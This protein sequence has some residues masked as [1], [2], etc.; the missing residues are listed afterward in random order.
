MILDELDHIT[1][2]AQSLTSLFS[3]PNSTPSTLRII[4][5][6]NTH[7]LTSSSSSTSSISAASNVRTLHF[8]PYTPAQLSE[9]LQSRLKSLT[10]VDDDGKASAD[11]KKFLP[12]STLML[13]TKKVAAL[14]GDVRSL[15]EVLRGAIDLA[16]IASASLP[17]P[18]Q[19]SD[20]NPL[21]TAAPIVTPTH[22]LAALKAYTPSSTSTSTTKSVSP[23]VA[24]VSVAT[25]SEIVAKVGNLGLHARLVILS[26]LLASKRLEA[27]LAISSTTT[28]ASP[29]KK[30]PVSPMKR[31]SSV[32][33]PTANVNGVGIDANQLHTY[34]S[35]ILNRSDG[36]VLEPV[37]RGEYG[38]LVGVL[39]GVG[40]I[41]MGGTADATTSTGAKRA[42]GR[43]ASFGGA[44]GFGGTG[45]GKGKGDVRLAKGVRADEVLRGLG[46]TV[47]ETV[48][49]AAA[50]GNIRQE[51]VRGIWEKEKA[52]LARDLKAIEREK[53]KALVAANGFDGASED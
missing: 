47:S 44:N 12:P 39:E 30:S 51:E 3:L 10:E 14:T 4:G 26:A 18:T 11:V 36:G 49:T 16:V 53:G 35:T 45:K 19:T 23:A 48:P 13:L 24:G 41:S 34:Y 21:A 32:P 43:T 52:R 22:V 6:A 17:S 46:I 7:T 37:S 2:T 38:D 33:N 15:F 8:A 5:I 50:E 9:I 27:G 40:L 29:T 31:S 20:N 28:S 25:N 1:P 42:F